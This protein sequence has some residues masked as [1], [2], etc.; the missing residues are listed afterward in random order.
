[1][2]TSED[3]E[4]Q[5]QE[6]KDFIKS[7][8]QSGICR[9][10]NSRDNFNELFKAHLTE[11]LIENS[12]FA[13]PVE[14]K[15]ELSQEEI[16]IYEY[17]KKKDETKSAAFRSALYVLNDEEIG[18]RLK[19]AAENFVEVMKWFKK[20]INIP[21]NKIDDW[22]NLMKYFKNIRDRKNRATYDQFSVR[23]NELIEK[24]LLEEIDPGTA[25][26]FDELDEIIEGE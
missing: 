25:G 4:D 22:Q 1:L 10:Y 17:F 18:D 23:L 6:L 20:L 9:E 8:R 19:L 12:H 3:N 15:Y 11:F 16:E 21:E 13:P 7:V 14:E 24:H 5:Y 26:D 2:E